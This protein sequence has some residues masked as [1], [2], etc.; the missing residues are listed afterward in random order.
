M[1]GRTAKWRTGWE[2]IEA[3]GW[4][5]VLPKL[6]DP[7]RYNVP[8]GTPQLMLHRMG[9]T[10][11]ADMVHWNY[12]P[13]WAAGKGRAYPNARVEKVV[14]GSGYYKV[15][16]VKRQRG[17]MPVDGWYEWPAVDG[18]K[19]PYLIAGKDRAPLWL[20]TIT[21]FQS[22]DASNG[23]ESGMAII[24]ADAVGG[25]IDVHDRRPIV[26]RTEDALAWVDPDVDTEFAAHLLLQL[27]RPSDDFEWWKVS[28]AVGSVKNQ[29][30]ELM[31][32][33]TTDG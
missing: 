19:Q 4:G 28:P 8:P 5:S 30:R 22:G 1:C 2:L 6:D 13:A 24:T 25:M 21:L 31:D 11:S 32:P 33:I 7:P 9:G 26:L 23:P 12:Q 17:I 14:A 29:G 15:P 3:F 20:A 27:A 16:W 10:P 18:K